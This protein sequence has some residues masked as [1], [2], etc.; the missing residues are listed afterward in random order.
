[1]GYARHVESTGEKRN[2]YKVLLRNPQG[3]RQLGDNSRVN[4]IPVVRDRGPVAALVTTVMNL[5]V[6]QNA[7]NLLR[8]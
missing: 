1:V 4:W 3:K 8:I 6:S 2:G 5:R 7:G